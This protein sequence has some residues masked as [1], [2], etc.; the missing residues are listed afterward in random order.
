MSTI[1]LV[2]S[3][4]R[5]QTTNA[6]T[7]DGRAAQA[8]SPI[9]KSASSFSAELQQL[10]TTSAQAGAD[11]QAVAGGETE[12]EAKYQAPEM[13]PGVL[14][15][16]DK[17][18]DTHM[19]SQDKAAVGFPFSPS[20]DPNTS[21][22]LRMLAETILEKRKLGYLTGPLTAQYLTSDSPYGVGNASTWP[23]FQSTSGQ[24]ALAEILMRC[25]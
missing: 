25:R 22:G 6:S 5:L 21:M 3:S 9:Q 14:Y 12:D 11:T 13:Q 10:S 17:W 15:N 18:I 16:V 4:Q 19:S 20:V 8:I 24:Q 2:G 23:E 1:D 7:S